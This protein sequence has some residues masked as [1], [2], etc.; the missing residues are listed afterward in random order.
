[1]GM[2]I[3]PTLL[4]MSVTQVN[5]TVNT[6]LASFFPGGPTYLFYGIRLVQFPLG[7]FGVA[8]GTALLPTLSAQAARGELDQLRATLSY[9]L[10][11]ILFIILPSMAGLMLLREPIIHLFFE[12]GM[13]T[14]EDTA[15]TAG[16]LLAFTVGLWAF[17]MVRILTAA[18]Y[19][20]Q[21]TKTPALAA[22]VSMV[23]NIVLALTLMDVLRHV[24]LALATAIAAM[25]NSGILLTAL[26]R[27]LGGLDWSALAKSV[28]RSLVAVAPVILASLWIADLAVWGREGDWIAKAVVLFVGIG[29]SV[30]GYIGV[31]A[32]LRSEELE[33]G[34]RMVKTKL[35]LG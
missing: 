21:D 16:A 32:L 23:T 31:H 11:M 28:G 13:F 15:G 34:W 3:V 5:L 29:L 35:R 27:K 22:V 10:R 26:S 24:G 19:S 33:D 7:I 18:F 4:G 2:L 30:T 1:M 12:H 20:M 8:L 25:V 17:A 6:I 9:G 14:A